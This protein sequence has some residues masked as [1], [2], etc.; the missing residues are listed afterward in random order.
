MSDLLVGSEEWQAKQIQKAIR[1]CIE[2]ARSADVVVKQEWLDRG[3]CLNTAKEVS[4][5]MRAEIVKALE[6]LLDY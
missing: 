5:E 1:M 2:K 3:C 4:L 6:E